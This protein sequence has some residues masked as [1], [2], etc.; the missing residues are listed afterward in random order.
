MPTGH[1][2]RRQGVGLQTEFGIKGDCE[3]TLRYEML[4]EPELRDVEFSGTGLSMRVDL[5]RP[6]QKPRVLEP[7]RAGQRRNAVHFLWLEKCR[8]QSNALQGVSRH[9]QEGSA[10][11]RARGAMLSGFTRPSR[12]KRRFRFSF[13]AHPFGDEDL[14]RVC[15]A[16]ST[17]V[18]EKHRCGPARHRLSHLGGRRLA[19]PARGNTA[20]EAALSSLKRPIQGWKPPIR[21]SRRARRPPATQRPGSH[22]L[23]A[24]R[25]ALVGIVLTLSFAAALGV[26]GF[27][28]GKP[29]ASASASPGSSARQRPP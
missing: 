15:I 27:P 20:F 7:R 4:K 2:K 24:R 8:G 22:I 25:A 26:V 6:V 9:G 10:P 28:T 1:D 19:D 16:G 12:G 13:F 23:A 18:P 17:G 21:C 29:Q 3:I 11:P 14:K 5:E